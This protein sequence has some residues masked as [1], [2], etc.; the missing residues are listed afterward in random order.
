[1]LR[2]VSAVAVAVVL[3]HLLLAGSAVDLGTLLG[4][5]SLAV[6]LAGIG[7]GLLARSRI[8]FLSDTVAL[9]LL[10]P[11]RGPLCDAVFALG[12]VGIPTAG[13]AAVLSLGPVGFFLGRRLTGLMSGGLPVLVLGLA[14]GELLVTLGAAG[15]FSA[16]IAGP[17]AAMTL[18][19]LVE[20]TGEE[21]KDFE[22]E[23]PAIHALPV[24]VALGLL[25]PVFLRLVPGYVEPSVH[26]G[27][28][29][30]WALLLPALA[31]AWPASVLVGEGRG[32]RWLGVIAGLALAATIVH[33]ARSLGLYQNAMAQVALT[34]SFRG[35]AA[36][37][38]PY[39]T[40]WGA[41]LLSF[42]G[43][44]AAG[45]G[46][47]LASLRARSAGWLALGCAL[48][49]AAQYYVVHDA[50]RGPFV[51]L[52]AAAGAAALCAPLALHPRRGWLGLPLVVVPFLL[53][54]AEQRPGFDEV[55][56]PGEF[57]VDAFHRTLAADITSFMTP[58]P[59]S[60]ALEG[61]EAFRLTF[62]N[63]EPLLA[64]NDDG[65]MQST[66]RVRSHDAH[67]DGNPQQPERFYG[68]RVGGSALHAGH[69]P[70]GSEGSVGRLTRLFAVR[71]R[72]F[73]TGLGAELLAAD[74]HDAGLSE[75][76]SVSSPAPFERQF[77][78][79]LLDHMQGSAWT[80]AAVDEPVLAA[81]AG[82][83][84]D[85]ATVLVS[86][87]RDSWPGGRAL[88]SREHV[89]RLANLLQPGGRCLLWL[90]TAGVSVRALRAH[91]AAFT[92]VFGA[93]SAAFVE[94]RELDAP[95]V[96]LVGWRD[97]E[98]RPRADEIGAR[99]PW[100][101]ESGLRTR[102]TSLGDLGA[103]LLRDG[104]AMLRAAEEWPVS[105][106]SR[107]VGSR[108]RAAGSWAAVRAVWD[109]ASRLSGVIEEAPDRF[110]DAGELM[111]GLAA[112]TR[113]SYGLVGL[114]ETLLEIKR[115]V[116]WDRFDVEV[117]HYV[118]AAALDPGNPLL[119]LALAALLEPLAKVGDYGR[120]AEV[121]EATGAR[122][123]PSWRLALLE[124]WVQQESLEPEAAEA[125]LERARVRLGR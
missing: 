98:G 72:S 108:L 73:V 49:V 120:F 24:G 63:R 78:I 81:R 102:L 42:A 50:V 111:D 99:L 101:D 69:E 53:I 4:P 8:P 57:G 39:V 54:P 123:M 94:P 31:V 116:D 59:D 91:M 68:L 14:A 34:R 19:L 104:E 46:L 114:N 124:A 122:T 37:H 74:L 117:G 88:V 65:T 56:R 64:L 109:P 16:W 107:P 89:A 75:Q 105:S 26:A 13:V 100:P 25:A 83:R 41:W 110:R 106:R 48:G 55:R 43:L 71:G 36:V 35:Y 92:E 58:G 97:S 87:A 32:A 79:I 1:M 5:A 7:F 21:H 90:D 60:N 10:V 51:L 20:W 118:R 17:L 6:L 121:Y 85:H 44:V 115:D 77:S 27:A 125:A 82:R 40:E 66:M 3:A 61:R 84:G 47:A 22:A 112:H 33:T 9:A 2:R 15:W 28:D 52:L 95:F 96:L 30:L 103:L 62:T 12:P 113:Y 119:H 45:L 29:V 93:N 67:D 18:A 38:T 86:P 11:L 76:I 23:R 80:A 70:L